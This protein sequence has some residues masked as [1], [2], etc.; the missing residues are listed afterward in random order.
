MAETGEDALHYLKIT[1]HLPH[2]VIL[3]LMLPGISGLEVRR[4][5]RLPRPCRSWCSPDTAK[6]R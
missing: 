1:A 3:D 5:V 6:N 2:L 4:E